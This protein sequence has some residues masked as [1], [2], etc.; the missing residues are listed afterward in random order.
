MV[1]YASKDFLGSY[2]QT[3]HLPYGHLEI[4]LGELEEALEEARHAEAILPVAGGWD[5]VGWDGVLA[6]SRDVWIHCGSDFE[7]Q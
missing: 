2:Q 6:G 5:G 3:P 4:H 1:I 7:T